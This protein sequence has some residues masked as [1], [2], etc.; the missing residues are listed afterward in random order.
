[1]KGASMTRSRPI[2]FLT[3]AAVVP[4]VAL[5]VAGCGGGGGGGATAATPPTTSAGQTAT[6]G[7]AGTGGLG[8]TLVASKG[9]RLSLFQADKGTKSACPGAC[10]KAW[11]P[12]RASG[13]P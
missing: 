13:K 7:V 2:T 1:M 8:K 5:V 10:A 3:T 12:L 4:L 11:P 9:R 6:V